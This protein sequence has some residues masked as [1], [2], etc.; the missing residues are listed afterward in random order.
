[1]LVDHQGSVRERPQRKRTHLSR[2]MSRGNDRGKAN[3]DPFLRHSSALGILKP[4][5]VFDGFN[6][7]Q[8]PHARLVRTAHSDDGSSVF[9][10]DELVTPFFPFGPRAT[11]FSV[12]D[13]KP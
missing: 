5:I 7:A 13:S 4:N 1:M 12:F 6:M 8:L 3:W 9:A 11:S 10:S 2:R